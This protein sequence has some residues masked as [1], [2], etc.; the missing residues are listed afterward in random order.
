MLIGT[1]VDLRPLEASDLEP[2]REMG[3]DTFIASKIVRHFLVG[4]EEQERWFELLEARN[5]CLY[6]TIISK[7]AS[8]QSVAG[9][10]GLRHLDWQNR[11]GELTMFIHPQYHGKGYGTEAVTLLCEY[12]F[13]RINLHKIYLNVLDHNSPAIRAYTKA[14]FVLEGTLKDEVWMGGR[15]NNMKRMAIFK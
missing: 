2:L 7:F 11:K 5:D 13:K 9:M 15:Y 1:T 8:F 4:K 14:G 12:C 3:N 10:I 6:F